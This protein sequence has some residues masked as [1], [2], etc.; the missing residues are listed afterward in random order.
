MNREILSEINRVR[1]IM[2]VRLI[3]EAP[4]NP[5]WFVSNSNDEIM[6]TLLEINPNF[7]GT[8]DDIT[9]IM[10][11]N[12][13]DID[14]PFL[15]E[16]RQSIDEVMSQGKSIDEILQSPVLRKNVE[17]KFLNKVKTGGELLDDFVEEFYLAN[18]AARRLSDSKTISDRVK[19][20]ASKGIND[21]NQVESV[22]FRQVDEFTL[23]N[24]KKLPEVIRKEIKDAITASVTGSTTKKVTD[25]AIN[26]T[27][28][29]VILTSIDD[30]TAATKLAENSNWRK[31]T[32]AYLRQNDNNIE[33]VKSKV[34]QDYNSW[35]RAN[36]AKGISEDQA[37]NKFATWFNTI[38]GLDLF[39]SFKL[40]KGNFY[41]WLLTWIGTAA[42]SVL[43]YLYYD[44][45][46]NYGDKEQIKLIRDKYP[47]LPKS[48]R[49]EYFNYIAS[50]LAVGGDRTKG[51]QIIMDENTNL[52]FEESEDNIISENRYKIKITLGDKTFEMTSDN[53]G[54]D[55]FVITNTFNPNNNNSQT[56]YD[57]TLD[58][59]KKFLKDIKLDGT[60][61]KNDTD[62]S[63]YWQANG[64]DY[65]YD[66]TA[67]TF[68]ED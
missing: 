32:A 27:I 35:V 37:L 14:D 52:T 18:P 64:K 44:E 46:L 1:E 30:A 19:Y 65:K 11:R 68:V 13:D 31:K 12:I 28:N 59:F 7:K 53:E 40:D 42:G 50:Q 62:N 48:L 60:N 63:G 41:A 25:E 21:L 33:K 20:A 67:K 43:T 58:G 15:R 29:E 61:A 34:K 5:K 4:V 17:N 57:Q 23:S 3:S 26:S 2:G 8:L 45:A 10:S 36:K 39:K 54:E 49:S 22:L 38:Y 16:F 51:F 47:D 56:N 9:D 6:S 55:R 24:G 66:V